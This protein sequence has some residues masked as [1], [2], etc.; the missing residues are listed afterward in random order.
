MRVKVEAFK[1]W[2]RLR[3]SHAG[4]RYCLSLGLPDGLVNRSIA[5]ARAAIIEGDLAT[6]NFD[7]SLTKYRPQKQVSA[8][9]MTVIELVKD[10]PNTRIRRFTSAP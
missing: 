2:L 8:S 1:G 3:W 9:S 4:E 10:S 5:T 6:E 7:L